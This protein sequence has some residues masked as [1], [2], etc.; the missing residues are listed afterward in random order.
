MTMPK[1]SIVRPDDGEMFSN[2]PLRMRLLE[3]GSST[4]HRLG[5]AEIM[6]PRTRAGPHSTATPSTMRGST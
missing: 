4:D 5:M 1:V 3:D 2:G 6:M